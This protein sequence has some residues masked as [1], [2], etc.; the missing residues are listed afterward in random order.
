MNRV[1]PTRRL[2]I[3]ATFYKRVLPVLIPLV[4]L[5]MV[6]S[7]W[8][9]SGVLRGTI[10]LGP[11]V[12]ILAA[13]AFGV[14]RLLNGELADEVLDGGDYL[15]VRIGKELEDVPIREI[16]RIAESIWFKQPSRLELVLRAP[17]KFGRVISF[18]PA[19]FSMVPFTRS[20]TFHELED[21][22]SRARAE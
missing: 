12:S 21:R 3:D 17:G 14:N 22:L 9:S 7:T 11:V 1:P 16:E 6:A 20:A 19:G 2:S 8:S 18:I 4:G 15:R 10:E 5:A 13:I